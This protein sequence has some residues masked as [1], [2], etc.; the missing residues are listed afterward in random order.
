MVQG[1][2]TLQAEELWRLL[3]ETAHTIPMYNHH[4]RFAQDVMLKEKPQISAKELAIQMNIA[5]GE[6]I[7]LLDELRGA[8]GLVGTTGA[9]AQGETSTNR[10]L[11][12]F[13][14]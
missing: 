3:V 6:A 12:D 8:R 5:E 2:N 14:G 11:L 4:K 7:V 13:D 10:T 1:S 9:T